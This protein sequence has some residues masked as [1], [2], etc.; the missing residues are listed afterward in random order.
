MLESEV[1]VIHP[2]FAKEQGF[3]ANKVEFF[4]KTFMVVNVSPK[5][6]LEMLFF[7]LNDAEIDFFERELRWKTYTTKEVFLTNKY[8]KLI[9]KKE[10]TIVALDP[11]YETFVVYVV[12]LTNFNLDV[13][14]SCRSQIAGL[15]PEKILTMIP[16]M[17]ILMAKMVII[18]MSVLKAKMVTMAII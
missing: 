7:T 12:S 5:V 4:E 11:E 14:L 9:E 8:I 6:V 3:Q 15:I 1:N 18:T 13:Y 16:V 10:F 17:R 2:I